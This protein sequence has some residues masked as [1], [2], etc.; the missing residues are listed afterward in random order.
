M[1][2]S[3]GGRCDDRHEGNVT[4]KRPVSTKEMYTFFTLRDTERIVSVFFP[5]ILYIFITGK[6]YLVIKKC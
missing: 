4:I 3:K 1:R 6:I 2:K 5:S